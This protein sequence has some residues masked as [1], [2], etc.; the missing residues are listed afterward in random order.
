[1]DLRLVQRLQRNVRAIMD[2]VVSRTIVLRF[3]AVL[4]LAMAAGEVY[5]CDVS[6]TCLNFN[7]SGS[8]NDCDQPSGDNCVCCCH[9]IVP[10]VSPLS[11]QVGEIIDQQS[12]SEPQNRLLSR[13]SHIDHPPQ[14]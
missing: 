14:L 8:V 1:M 7:Q 13:P 3:V 6:D 11:L 2:V 12:P 5:A 10:P 9:H 4:L